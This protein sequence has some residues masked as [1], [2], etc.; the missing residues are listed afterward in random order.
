M[1]RREMG[2]WVDRLKVAIENTDKMFNAP[3]PTAEELAER[4]RKLDAQNVRTISRN[5]GIVQNAIGKTVRVRIEKNVVLTGTI[6]SANLTRN[7]RAEVMLEC[8]PTKQV[9]GPF[10]LSKLPR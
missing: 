4:Q 7:Q 5:H 9:R 1:D 3:P 10:F 8:G 2:E 6:I